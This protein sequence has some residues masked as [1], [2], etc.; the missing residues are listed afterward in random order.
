VGKERLRREIVQGVTQ[1]EIERVWTVTDA[2]LHPDPNTSDIGIALLTRAEERVYDLHG[3]NPGLRVTRYDYAVD[4]QISN[5]RGPAQF[6]LATHI[7]E[8]NGAETPANLY[9]TTERWYYGRDE[10]LTTGR[11]LLDRLAQEQLWQGAN[12]SACQGQTRYIYDA[13]GLAAWQTSATQG[14]L[15]EVWQAGDG[16]A[17]CAAGWLKTAAYGYDSRGNRTSATD[18]RGRV[19]SSVYD[20]TFHA[21]PLTETV[22]PAPALGGAALTTSY[23]YYGLNP[24][25]GGSGRYGQLQAVTDP[26]SAVTRYSYDAFGRLSAVWR[27]GADFAAAPTVQ[28]AYNDAPFDAFSVGGPPMRVTQR[29]RA[30]A[31]A[32]NLA[33]TDPR[34]AYRT[35][36]TF[37]D[38]LGQV[39][40]T[41]AEGATP[42]QGVLVNQGYNALGLVVSQT[43]PYFGVA[44]TIP[45]TPSRVVLENTDTIRS[46]LPQPSKVQVSILW[47]S[48]PGEHDRKGWYRNDFLSS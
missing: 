29:Q 20:P 12:G 43:V 7:I 30:D 28:Y 8:Y 1:R 42:A 36:F 17:P 13:A 5:T 2:G 45:D 23:R 15:R 3:A 6:G 33:P 22:T 10:A 14:L 25:S 37:Y 21:W 18:G 35:A 32:D 46:A 44:N 16:G 11:H 26:N 47:C 24:E 34:V 4:H 19:S 27:P 48:I 41:Q 39:I 38:G 40:Q 9:R 31:E